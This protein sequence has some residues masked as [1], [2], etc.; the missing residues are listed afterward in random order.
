M[1]REGKEPPGRRTEQDPAGDSLFLF[2]GESEH[3]CGPEGE[4]AI[5]G[6][7]FRPLEKEALFQ[8]VIVIPGL[9]PD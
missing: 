3:D 5:Q 8:Q 7:G 6:S 4:R 1:Q 9:L 2:H